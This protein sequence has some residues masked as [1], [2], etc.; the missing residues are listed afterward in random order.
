[1]VEHSGVH[2]CCT[3]V[4]LHKPRNDFAFWQAQP[5]EVRL[6]TLERIRQEYHRWKYGAEPGFQRVCTIAQ[7]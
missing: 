2:V 7:R 6:A 1:M 5:Y 4:S 3:R